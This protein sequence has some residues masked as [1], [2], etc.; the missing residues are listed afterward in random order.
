MGHHHRRHL[1]VDVLDLPDFS[2]RLRCV[3][4]S[5]RQ[6]GPRDGRIVLADLLADRATSA[7]AGYCDRGYHSL[8]GGAEALRSG[9]AANVRG[10]WHLDADS[11]LFSVGAGL[12][13]QQIQLRCRSLDRASR[14]IL[15]ADLLRHL[16]VDQPTSTG[17]RER[18][19]NADVTIAAEA[20]RKRKLRRQR[21]MRV[22]R[23]AI[24]LAWAGVIVFPIFWMISTSFK[25]AG[26]W[27][28][29]PPHW[30]PHE[31]TLLNYAQIFAFGALDPTLSRQATEQAF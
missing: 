29:W 9:G 26:E 22:G 8:D 4:A 15:N 24:L 21:G 19:L 14:H 3:T 10:P 5:T 1:A 18:A 28:A 13:I 27:V 2:V 20:A 17:R 25:D 7:Q 6:C 31:P 11:C 30:L 12:G 16:Y 23:H